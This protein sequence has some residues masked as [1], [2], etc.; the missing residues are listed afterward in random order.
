MV[1]LVKKFSIFSKTSPKIVVLI[2]P[3]TGGFFLMENFLT[4]KIE[5][6]DFFMMTFLT[7][8]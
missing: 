5:K 7:R 4:K 6:Y 8:F 2:H 1:W 3:R